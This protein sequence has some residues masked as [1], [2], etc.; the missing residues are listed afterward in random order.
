MFVFRKQR[1]K[2]TGYSARKFPRSRLAFA[3]NAGFKTLV[4]KTRA[5][6]E[7][8]TGFGQLGSGAAAVA[9]RS[10]NSCIEGSSAERVGGP[11]VDI[12]IDQF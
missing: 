5:G 4:E 6:P 8:S 12:W 7:G 2:G 1:L 10:S 3:L 9:V 11:H